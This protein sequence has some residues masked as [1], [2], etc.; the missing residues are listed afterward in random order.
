MRFKVWR[1]GDIKMKASNSKKE[2]VVQF[3]KDPHY[4]F[5]KGTLYFQKN[6]LEKAL[7]YFKKS[8]ETDPKNP[9]THYNLACLMSRMG[10]LNEANK[11]FKYIV[12]EIDPDFTECYFLKAINYGL[13]EELSK[14]EELL[15]IYL[16]KSPNGEMAEEATEILYVL[17][18]EEDELEEDSDLWEYDIYPDLISKASEKEI[19]TLYENDEKF[20]SSLELGLYRWE[21]E[22]KEKVI[23]FLTI[24]E[25]KKDG[26][27]LL[28]E[29][30]KNPWIKERIRQVALLALKK[31]DYKGR[32]Q[33][34]QDGQF[35]EVKSEELE[36]I[37]PLWK[38][39]WQQVL[40]CVLKRMEKSKEYDE[41]CYEDIKA[42]WLD[43]IN[44]SF[45][46]V[47]SIRKVETWAAGLEYSLV[48]FHFLSVPQ[49]EIAE[50]YGVSVS[51]VADKF[52]KINI[53]LDLDKKT[54]QNMVKYLHSLD[55]QED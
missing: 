41:D 17:T 20:K 42:M 37:K 19:K 7:V 38:D 2:K 24:S 48:R 36:I 43:F 44:T 22:L 54:R 10:Q 11:I 6:K 12:E 53:V 8:V 39:E 4:Y 50:S 27:E 46:E 32:L 40:N 15:R 16:K 14:A 34:F 49:K 45:P 18:E 55:R 28:I 5:D 9:L 31:M 33:I 13:L 29:F 23:N 30:V 21:D 35:K 51:S 52:K 47:P 1:K 26:E 3:E 25:L